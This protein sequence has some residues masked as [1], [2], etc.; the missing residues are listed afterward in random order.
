MGFVNVPRYNIGCDGK[1]CNNFFASVE[2]GLDGEE[3]DYYIFEAMTN[4][5]IAP[6][7]DLLHESE[8]TVVD[9]KMYCPPC[10]IAVTNDILMVHKMVMG[11]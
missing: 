4:E 5:L 1:D 9:G 11:L 2:Y 3:V 8:W 10:S 7:I 6:L